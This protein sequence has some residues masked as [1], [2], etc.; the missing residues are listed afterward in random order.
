MAITEKCMPGYVNVLFDLEGT[1]VERKFPITGRCSVRTFK[2]NLGFEN[3]NRVRD[4]YLLLGHVEVIFSGIRDSRLLTSVR[5]V[6]AISWGFTTFRRQ[7]LDARNVLH[8]TIA[9]VSGR[10]QQ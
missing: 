7:A 3:S 5:C 4:R 8:H 6:A 1:V 10:G 2:L 9:G